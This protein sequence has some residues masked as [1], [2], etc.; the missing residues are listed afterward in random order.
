MKS[1]F[2]SLIERLTL[3]DIEILNSLTSQESIS[4]FSA[5]TKKEIQDFTKISESKF[6]KTLCRLEAMNFIE[7][8]PGNREHLLFVTDFGQSAI[9]NIYERGNV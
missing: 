2:S 5:K 4:R 6:R 1:H 9:Q 8:V 7:I 3:D